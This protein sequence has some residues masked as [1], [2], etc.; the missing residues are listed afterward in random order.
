M[1]E[2]SK[3]KPAEPTNP[4]Q[5]TEPKAPVSSEEPA[6][7]ATALIPDDPISAPA[8]ETSETSEAV[9]TTQDTA[10][11]L[12]DN[13]KTE[14]AVDDIVAH[15]GTG[16]EDASADAAPAHFHIPQKKHGFWH[17]WLGTSKGRWLTFIIIVAAA[18]VVAATPKYRYYTLNTAGVRAGASVTVVDDITQLPLKNVKVTIAGA[19][20]QTDEAGIARFTRLRLGE[21]QVDVQQPGFAAVHRTIIVGWGSNPLPDVPLAATGTRYTIMVNDYITGKPLPGVQ[22]TTG[23]ATALS[24]NHGK[25]ELTL[26]DT[27]AEGAQITL[28][29]DG[30]RS[31]Q[32]V[33]KAASQSVTATMV[34]A[35]KVVFVSKASGNYD[36][37]K[38]DIDGANKEV[39]LPA[40]G[41]ENGN[42]SLAA[43]TDGSHAALVSTRD[44]QH[45]GD[46]FLLNTLTLVDVNE[47]TSTTL[48]HADQIQLIDW[49]GS[50][51]VFEQVSSDPKVP[52]A[53]R[54]SVIS[55][56]YA[57][58]SRV[59]LGVAPKMNGVF[60]AQGSVYYT[61]S[62]NDDNGA[63]QP[64]LYRIS[65]DGSGRQ[66]V[67]DKEVWGGIR[68]DY[69]TIALQT[70]DGWTAYNFKTGS[71]SSIAGPATFTSRLYRDNGEH[72]ASLYVDQI[73][74][75][76]Y[77]VSA[78]KDIP[79]QSQ[80]GMNYPVQ[81]FGDAVLYRVVTAT[82][83]ADYI[84]APGGITHKVADVANTYGF[85]S[86]Q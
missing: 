85:S 31:G 8:P 49:V 34:T 64:G 44:N 7:P 56:D 60:S 47:G 78:N 28:T 5:H 4:Q 11:P 83:T 71:S 40:T 80:E 45:D 54:Y 48:A 75:L 36:L 17:A 12:L 30:Y 37:Y 15:E 72:S 35:R 13:E 61:V 6:V 1:A 66:R 21:T 81:W 70:A 62:A 82:Q 27:S 77:D 3:K 63:L 39:L 19:S 33:L 26:E 65:P 2:Q 69:N 24:D 67:F 23:D 58:N 46:G 68:T 25:V 42:L 86:G 9:E 16:E 38:S 84:T 73:Q 32:A 76:E 55:Y 41:N 74:L 51:L 14:R 57:T 29:K 53:S 59:Q 43:S 50:R 20:K 10:D 79:V 22:A 52:I 18:A